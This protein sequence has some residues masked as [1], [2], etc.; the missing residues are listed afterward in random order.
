M[1]QLELDKLIIQN[2]A[3]LEDAHRRI[4]SL[5][6]KIQR[7]LNKISKKYAE[8]NYFKGLFQLN[9]YK[10]W[11]APA[12]WALENSPEDFFAYFQLDASTTSGPNGE[13]NE[14]WLTTLCGAGYG[15]YGFHLLL[16]TIKPKKKKDRHTQ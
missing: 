7:E 1:S 16:D 15:E 8:S 6:I 13:E 5:E 9:D 10:I 11:L 14:Y 4:A 2:L 12:D 3:D